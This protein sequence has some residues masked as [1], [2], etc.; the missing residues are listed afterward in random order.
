MCVSVCRYPCLFICVCLGLSVS[1]SLSVCVFTCIC[2][3]MPVSTCL[4]VS[5]YLPKS[6]Y[7]CLS[8]SFLEIVEADATSNGTS[9]IK[10]RSGITFVFF[11]TMFYS[12]R[13]FTFPIL[14]RNKGFRSSYLST[15][16]A[17]SD[18]LFL[19]FFFLCKNYRGTHIIW[20][21]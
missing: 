6:F 16:L 3:C 15:R 9:K 14:W 1:V 10:Y 8:V 13:F 17:L 5:V 18:F 20:D 7:M 11:G 19:W 4:F 12:C 21:F 2:Q